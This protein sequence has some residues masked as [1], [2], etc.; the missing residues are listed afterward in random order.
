MGKATLREHLGHGIDKRLR[1]VIFASD[2]FYEV[3]RLIILEKKINRSII[4][5]GAA[6]NSLADYSLINSEGID[7][8]S[9]PQHIKEYTDNC[10]KSLEICKR[11]FPDIPVEEFEETFKDSLEGLD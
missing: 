8:F 3:H 2:I 6:Y 5:E 7:K 1:V 11:L 9:D 10:H 4:E